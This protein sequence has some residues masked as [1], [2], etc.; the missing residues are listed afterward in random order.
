V[1][2]LALTARGGCPKAQTLARSEKLVD[3]ATGM[4]Y[5]MDVTWQPH[6]GASI[7]SNAPPDLTLVEH[8]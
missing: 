1:T 7:C 3:N 6:S 8:L 4:R 2:R 5:H